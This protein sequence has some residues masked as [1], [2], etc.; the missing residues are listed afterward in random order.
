[1]RIRNSALDQQAITSFATQKVQTVT[2]LSQILACSVVTV[3][4]RL[5]EWDALT[6]YNKNGRYYTLRSIAVFNKIGIW[7]YRDIYFSRY[8]TLKNT[9]IALAAK[10]MKGLTHT[11]LQEI[12]GLNPK[13]FMARFNELPGVRKERHENYIVYFSDDPETY[14]A[15]K[16]NRFPPEPSGFKLPPDALAI[17]ILV[18]LIHHPRM[19]IDELAAQLQHKGHAVEADS[20]AALFKQHQIDKKKLNTKS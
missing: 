9:V 18:E 17:V 12:I 3:R 4:R 15:Q 19:S 20:I 6:S 13:C 16:R 11:E 14:E 1:M 5:R 8:G 7:S 2:D 10:S